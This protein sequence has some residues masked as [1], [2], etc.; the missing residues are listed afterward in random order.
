MNNIIKNTVIFIICSIF[1]I[2]IFANEIA[3]GE[4]FNLLDNIE[5]KTDLSEKTKLENGGVSFIFT[6]DDLERMQ[7]KSLK[8]ILKTTYPFGYNENK[9]GKP[10]PLTFSTDAL[11]VS[12]MMRVFI[13]NQEITNGLYGSGISVIGDI[14]IGFVDHIEVYTQNPTYEYSTEATFVLV[15]LYTKVAQKDE[16]SKVELNYSSYGAN[17]VSGYHAQELDKWSYLTYISQTNLKRQEYN[18]HDTVLSRDK[19]RSHIVSSWYNDSNRI[20]LQA[21]KSK[22]DSF[23]SKSKDATP[24][25]ASSNMDFLHIGYDTKIDNL[26]FLTT[27]D[28][29]MNS[30]YFKDNIPSLTMESKLSSYVLTTEL[31]YDYITSSNKLVVGGKYRYKKYNLDNR[32]LNGITLTKPDNDTQTIATSFIENQYS[33]DDNSILTTGLSYSQVKNNNS[34]QNDNLLMYRLG[35]TYTT[36]DLVFKTIGSHVEMSLDPYLVDNTSYMTAGSKDVQSLDSILEHITYEH[37]QNKYELLLTHLKSKNY[38]VPTMPTMLLDNHDKDVL[39][40][41]ILARYSLNY[42]KYDKFFTT[43]SYMKKENLPIVNKIDI[44]TAVIRNLNSY[45]QFDIFNEVAFYRDSDI[46]KNFYDYSMG[47]KYHYSKDFTISLK[48]ENLFNKA[49][50]TIYNRVDVTTLSNPIPSLETPLSISPIDRRITI[51]LEYLF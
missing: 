4:I 24:I 12:S 50:E 18:S 51:N 40:K 3:K 30:S 39:T 11:F 19:K 31:K 33:L 10:D 32:I 38:L 47:I 22:D 14:D 9:Y 27:Y 34:N 44:Y 2:N 5:K 16:G 42:N 8:D 25:D 48:G 7:A 45:N 26:S 15:K 29:M 28:Y 46:K 36:H 20:L 35:H 41:G 1:N 43:I 21:I 17:R 49:K 6:R 37:E 23:M 13:D